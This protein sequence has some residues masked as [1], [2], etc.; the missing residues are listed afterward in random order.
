MSMLTKFGLAVLIT[1]L[2]AAY[3]PASQSKAHEP[4]SGSTCAISTVASSGSI[5]LAGVAKGTP[6]TSGQ[7]RMTVAGGSAG[8]STS[9][10]Q[11]GAFQIGSDGEA[12][13]GIVSVPRNGIYNIRLQVELDGETYKCSKRVGANI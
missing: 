5:S 1:G 2:G 7:Y 3:L 9:T 4:L 8:G 11:G 12:Q 13:T 6:G 10:S